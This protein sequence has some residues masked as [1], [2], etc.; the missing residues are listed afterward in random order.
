[1]LARYRWRLPRQPEGNTPVQ[2]P[3][4]GP[5][6]AKVLRARGIES[7]GAVFSYLNPSLGHPMHLEGLEAAVAR[8]R[9][10]GGRGEIVFIHG[11]YD[12]D[13]ITSTTIVRDTLHGL[14]LRP[15]CYIPDR[16]SEG[17][18]LGQDAVR[19]AGSRGATLLVLVDCGT[20]DVESVAL[21]RSI[22][23]DVVILDHHKPHAVIPD[24]N[25]MVNPHSSPGCSTYYAAAGVCFRLAAEIL[26]PGAAN[27]HDLAALG[28]IADVMPL[29]GDNR[30]IARAGLE[31]LVQP[32]RPA[33]RA[34]FQV[35]RLAGPITARQVAFI[36]APR[37]NAAGRMGDATRA[38]ELL[39]ETDPARALHLA[40]ELD[41]ENRRRQELC[42]QMLEEA[43]PLA[44]EAGFPVAVFAREN[45]AKGLLGLV[46][47]RLCEALGRPVCALSVSEGT[48]HGSARSTPDVDIVAAL[49]ECSDHLLR[50]GGHSRAAGFS[51]EAGRLVEF[52]D[53][54]SRATAD[55][56]PRRPVLAIDGV[57]TAGDLRPDWVRELERTEPCGE[58]NPRPAFL[59][60]NQRVAACRRVGGSGQHLKMRLDEGDIE[61]IWFGAGE[62]ADFVT[63]GPGVYDLVVEPRINDFRGRGSVELHIVDARPAA[64]GTAL[65][66]EAI[67]PREQVTLAAG[68]A[69]TGPEPISL[70]RTSPEPLIMHLRRAGRVPVVWS[71]G[72]QEPDGTDL[73]VASP[74][75]DPERLR[76]TVLRNSFSRVICCFDE[77]AISDFL[78]DLE[79][80]APGRQTLLRCHRALLELG[81]GKHRIDDY[82]SALE[83]AHAAS[84]GA[85]A[86][87]AERSLSVFCEIGVAHLSGEEVSVVHVAGKADLGTSAAFRRSQDWKASIERF[88]D[89]TGR[90][91]QVLAEWLGHAGRKPQ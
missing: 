65:T 5:L 39:A 61:C 26:G 58:Q 21:A 38:F 79:T 78:A 81:P 45:W 10:A 33:L 83:Q 66:G 4:V 75:L 76:D 31:A 23:M 43:L 28:T 9:L 59:L 6:L 69:A 74:P 14:G 15:H 29:L 82:V 49:S 91:P 89:F 64:S 40:T 7:P 27:M 73:V 13:G 46:A 24:A 51:L 62:H 19:L 36:L 17:Y 44:P 60:E 12:V 68:A 8:L 80:Y 86:I 42:Q 37:L 1:M 50:F 53:A 20:S 71:T 47:G 55:Y 11:D 72:R 34:L 88:Y 2:D 22:G 56:V 3:D 48:C 87:L 41:Q 85:A 32:V 90:S 18:G 67:T 84:A 30:A 54:L 57:I 77:E 35:S 16:E 70:P 63:G 25:V 52:R